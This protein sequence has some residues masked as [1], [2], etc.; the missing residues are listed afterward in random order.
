MRNVMR[1]PPKPAQLQLLVLPGRAK[2]EAALRAACRGPVDLVAVELERNETLHSGEVLELVV[3]VLFPRPDPGKTVRKRLTVRH[4]MPGGEP[5]VR[6]LVAGAEAL[7]QAISGRF[8]VYGGAWAP[9]VVSVDE[10]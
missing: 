1:K 2:V 3:V 5:N 7:G 9:R 8:R 4:V 6:A 10:F